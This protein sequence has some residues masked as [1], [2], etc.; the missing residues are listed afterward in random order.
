MAVKK[1]SKKTIIK[2]SKDT[3]LAALLKEV[4][5]MRRDLEL[6]KQLQ[7]EPGGIHRNATMTYEVA[8]LDMERFPPGYQVAV[9]PAD[10]FPPD[11]QVMVKPS[12]KYPPDYGVLVKSDIALPPTYEVRVKPGNKIDMVINPAAVRA[13]TGK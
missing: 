12:W 13:V 4:R 5:A 11:Y 7:P 2:K 3:E 10:I 9:T 1:T 8:A 6:I